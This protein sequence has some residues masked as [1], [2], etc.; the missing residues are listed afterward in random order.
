MVR[1]LR[2]QELRA[3]GAQD[4]TLGSF[5]HSEDV[6]TGRYHKID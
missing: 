2:Y 1:S 5:P 6:L 4:G 3:L